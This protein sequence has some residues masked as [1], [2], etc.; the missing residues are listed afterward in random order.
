MNF[1]LSINLDI[2]FEVFL[3]LVLVIFSALV[4]GAFLELVLEQS[5]LGKFVGTLFEFKTL[6]PGD[7]FVTRRLTLPNF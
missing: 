2:V 6:L 1:T 4:W 3:D 5:F 7:V